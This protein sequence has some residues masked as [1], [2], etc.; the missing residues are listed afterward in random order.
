[1]KIKIIIVVIVLALV[2]GNIFFAVKYFS[3]A[4][5]LTLVQAVNAEKQKSRKILEFNKQFIE[6]VLGGGKE[7]NFEARLKLE[8]SV[9]ALNDEE[10]L[11][12]W[13]NFTKSK[14]AAEAQTNVL[15]LLK[16]LANKM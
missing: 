6:E 3:A 1:M 13:Q 4:K 9:R 14:D 11:S 8:N 16:A 2:A 15:I 10:I 7:V 5:E 12:D